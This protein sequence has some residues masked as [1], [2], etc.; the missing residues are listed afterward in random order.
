MTIKPFLLILPL[1]ALTAACGG[2][3][4]NNLEGANATA[5]SAATK[6]AYVDVDS[7]QNKYQY[8]IDAKSQL[9]AKVKGY[10]DVIRQRE[11]ALQQ[12]QVSL[13]QRMQNGSIT[14]EAQ[15]KAEVS[16]IQRQQEAY[17][18]YCEEAQK[19]KD[20]MEAQFSKALQDSLDN[21]LSEYNK[22]KHYTL[23]LNKAV[24]LYAEKGMDITDEVAAGLNKRYK[25]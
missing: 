7:L 6:I 21:F 12:M 15:Y 22:T 13:Q 20:A 16:K 8:Y 2:D 10:Q 18:K 23:I 9:E 4:K 17:A 24:T 3:K 1:A 14:S 11:Q 19:E 25:K 5:S